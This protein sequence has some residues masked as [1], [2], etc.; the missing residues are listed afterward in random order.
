[1]TII[2][3]SRSYSNEMSHSLFKWSQTETSDH[4]ELEIFHLSFKNHRRNLIY[5][6][7][8]AAKSALDYGFQ[9]QMNTGNNQNIKG[10]ENSIVPYIGKKISKKWYAE[11]AIG[12]SQ[13]KNKHTNKS[14]SFSPY[15]LKG[16]FNM[17][18]FFSSLELSKTSNFLEMRYPK[19]ISEYLKKNKLQ[20]IALYT[21]Q[22][23]RFKLT[24]R[25]SSFNDDNN[26]FYQ[27]F[28]AKY[29]LS[30]DQ[31]WILIG[32]GTEYYR[33]KKN[34]S[35]Y[36]T[37]RKFLTFGPRVEMTFKFIEHWLYTLA[38]NINRFR[39]ENRVFGNGLY[40]NT[41]LQYR[42]RN[43]SHLRIGYE[44]VQSRQNSDKWNSSRTYLEF[45][46][47]W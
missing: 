29:N 21:P 25:L 22:K 40:L 23:F 2:L 17:S 47:F 18:Q 36:W 34:E 27:D 5:P 39:N 1:M 35:G 4:L 32:L 24:E 14:H 33:Y 9:Y 8:G 16:E 26:L 19:A 15:R 41:W 20:W 31:H 43:E 13:L 38:G 44:R 28:D 7:K 6:F 10:I 11:A 30:F 42:L 12:Y 46:C 3:P 37:P 45:H